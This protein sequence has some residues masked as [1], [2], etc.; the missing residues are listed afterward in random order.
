MSGNVGGSQQ[1]VQ[2]VDQGSCLIKRN[3]NDLI[4]CIHD[5]E[6][7]DMEHVAH[8]SQYATAEKKN[9]SSCRRNGNSLNFA[10]GHDFGIRLGGPVERMPDYV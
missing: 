1:A 7:T 2:G 6:V 5:E 9:W 8:H 4:S 10:L 3:L